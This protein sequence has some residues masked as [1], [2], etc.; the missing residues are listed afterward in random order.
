MTDVVPTDE[1]DDIVELIWMIGVEHE[2]RTIPEMEKLMEEAKQR[3]HAYYRQHYHLQPKPSAEPEQSGSHDSVAKGSATA[4]TGVG[5]A[6]AMQVLKQRLLA[7]AWEYGVPDV[8]RIERDGGFL[9]AV[10]VEAI[11]KIMEAS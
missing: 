11:N 3:I 2:S 6:L 4:T 9:N 10:S 7:A 1:L 8:E 5:E